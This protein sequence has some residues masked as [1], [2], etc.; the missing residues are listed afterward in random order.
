MS[1]HLRLGLPSGLFPSGFPTNKLRIITVALNGRWQWR[2]RRFECGL[3]V[4]GMVERVS[5]TTNDE[6]IQ[7]ARNVEQSGRQKSMR[8]LSVERR[9]STGSIHSVL[10]LDLNTHYLCQH[11]TA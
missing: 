2:K 11:L 10:H 5:V 4:S 8:E 7:F 1:I 9:M 3:E 6:I